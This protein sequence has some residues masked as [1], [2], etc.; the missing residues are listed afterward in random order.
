MTKQY[1]LIKKGQESITQGT[2]IFWFKIYTLLLEDVGE[3]CDDSDMEFI[4]LRL[5]FEGKKIVWEEIR[6]ELSRGSVA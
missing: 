4:S 5:L 2:L 1:R 6:N 3:G